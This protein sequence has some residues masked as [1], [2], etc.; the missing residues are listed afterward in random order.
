LVGSLA[1]FVLANNQLLP[2]ETKDMIRIIVGT[3]TGTAEFVADDIQG[4][5]AEHGI[6]ASVELTN[7]WFASYLSAQPIKGANEAFDEASTETWLLCTSTHGAGDVPHNLKPFVDAVNAIPDLSSI[8]FGVIGLGDSSY[9]TYC[10]AAK[11]LESLLKEKNADQLFDPI[12]A[13]AMSDDL[14]EDIILP[15]LTQHLAILKS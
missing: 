7:D 13:D 8:K 11:K 2:S 12:L 1:R 6:T 9:D 3:E 10:E 4:L 15:I 14:P 5:L